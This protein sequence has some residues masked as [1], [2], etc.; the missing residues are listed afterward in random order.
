M[1][2]VSKQWLAK[3]GTIACRIAIFIW[4]LYLIHKTKIRSCRKSIDDVGVP[5]KEIE[6]I[7]DGMN[8]NYN[9]EIKD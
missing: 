6:G 7:L 9:L 1:V 4:S 3:S 2:Q 5:L 8:A